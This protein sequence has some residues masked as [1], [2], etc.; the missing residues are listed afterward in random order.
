MIYDPENREVYFSTEMIQSEADA[1]VSYEHFKAYLR[2]QCK[3]STKNITCTNSLQRSVNV[4]LKI[5]PAQ[6]V[7]VRR[8][9]VPLKN[10]PAQLVCVRSKHVPVNP[11]LF[12]KLLRTQA[13]MFR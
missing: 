4:P 1:G 10:L 2:A 5:L 13:N 8:V 7:C 11:V 9:N 12:T 3:C 6:I